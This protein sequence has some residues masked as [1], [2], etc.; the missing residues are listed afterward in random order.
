MLH[1]QESYDRFHFCVIRTVSQRPAFRSQS[2]CCHP[3]GILFL[4]WHTAVSLPSCMGSTFQLHVKHARSA[5][6]KFC[7]ILS[8]EWMFTS[9]FNILLLQEHRITHARWHWLTFWLAPFTTD[10][11]RHKILIVVL[12]TVQLF[13]KVMP[14]S[15][16]NSYRHFRWI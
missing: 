16:T 8:K 13:C 5:L 10:F 11:A 7:I 2:T 4:L 3:L 15:Q 9:L 1:L 14:H 12:M 6:N